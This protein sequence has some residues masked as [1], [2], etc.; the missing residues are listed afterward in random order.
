MSN[1][2]Y[3]LSG[4]RPG[5]MRAGS[6]YGGA[7][8]HGVRISSTSAPRNF[9]SSAAVGL[10][11]GGFELADAVDISDNKK[12]A[13]QNLNDRLASYLE[14]VRNLETANANLELK[15]KEFLEKKTKVEGNDYSAYYATIRDLQ[16][17]V[18][19]ASFSSVN[20]VKIPKCIT[21]RIWGGRAAACPAGA[22]LLLDGFPCQ[23]CCTFICGDVFG[24]S[25]FSVKRLGEMSLRRDTKERIEL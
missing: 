17:K 18:R 9:S 13:M 8:G 23:T 14:K 16:D 6:V 12:M 15:I 10:G 7:G 21:R 20:M 1:L 2:S 22:R 24:S 11:S 5:S 3:R 4:S 25:S 19:A